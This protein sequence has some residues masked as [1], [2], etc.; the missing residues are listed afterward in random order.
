MIMLAVNDI[1]NSAIRNSEHLRETFL[2]GVTLAVYLQKLLNVG[3]R[4][5]SCR[6]LVAGGYVMASLF[7]HVL[8]VVF[9]SSKKKMI[10][11]HARRIVTMV[12]AF[13]IV[14]NRTDIQHPRRP[15]RQYASSPLSTTTN[16][17]VICA[18][19][20]SGPQPALTSKIGIFYRVWKRSIFIHLSPK[21]FAESIRKA[22][23]KCWVLF[24]CN[25]HTISLV[26]CLSCSD[27]GSCHFGA[28]F[29]S[30]SH[31]E[32]KAQ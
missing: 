5:A 18:V 17:A 7:H 21:A 26:D 19:S 25:R 24:T 8:S 3:L 32:R 13:N 9:G 30:R 27:D 2:S 16:V 10:W 15:V 11:S 6:M 28:T 14:R 31:S 4:N 29:S 23:R 1:P 12:K 22:L 20:G